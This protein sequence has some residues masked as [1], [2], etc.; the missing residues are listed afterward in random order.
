[1]GITT[2]RT[3]DGRAYTAHAG[4]HLPDHQADRL[5]HIQPPGQQQGMAHPRTAY[6][7][8]YGRV[9]SAFSDRLMDAA[10]TVDMIG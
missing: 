9:L 7:A 3:C 6:Q 5:G 2:R 1:L 10:T 4:G 8:G